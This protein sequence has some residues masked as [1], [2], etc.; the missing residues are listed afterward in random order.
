MT[1]KADGLTSGES[2]ELGTISS[3]RVFQSFRCWS[4]VP[5]PGLLRLRL[6]LEQDMN[7][8]GF[9]LVQEVLRLGDAEVS[10][11][12]GPPAAKFDAHR[13]RPAPIQEDQRPPTG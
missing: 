6:A 2:I 11:R 7:V 4:L 8:T 13:V 1:S 10:R 12:S 5:M 9:G 3:G